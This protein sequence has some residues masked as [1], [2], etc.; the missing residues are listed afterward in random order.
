MGTHSGST[1]KIV[2]MKVVAVLCLLMGS[3]LAGLP[4][5][6]HLAS[7]PTQ[8]DFSPVD[9]EG[10]WYEQRF[11]TSH[12]SVDYQDKAYNVNAF[13]GGINVR[14]NSRNIETQECNP[15][16]TQAR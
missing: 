2:K 11:Y 4:S 7:I 13:D 14:L 8:P 9:F 1:S 12:P 3:A 5:R 6:C 16:V 15:E 10:E